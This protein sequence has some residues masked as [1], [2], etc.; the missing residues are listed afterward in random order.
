VICQ[1]QILYF[2]SSCIQV[3][4]IALRHYDNQVLVE[5]RITA[6]KTSVTE[7]Q[8]SERKLHESVKSTESQIEAFQNSV[9]SLLNEHTNKLSKVPTPNNIVASKPAEEIAA[10]LLPEQ[11]EKER[12]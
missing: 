7:I 10:S 4:P 9:K 1:R 2:C 12:Q 3:L 11:K 6:V 5:S 8:C